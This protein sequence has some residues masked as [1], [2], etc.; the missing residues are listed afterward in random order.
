MR[1]HR[2]TQTRERAG[3][4]LLVRMMSVT[5]ISFSGPF[6]SVS[7]FQADF[8][9]L[10]DFSRQSGRSPAPSLLPLQPCHGN[11]ASSPPAVP[12]GSAPSAPAVAGMID[13]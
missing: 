11:C 10:S 2:D 12:S 1:P 4:L 8:I 3:E 6:I 5:A 7:D 13:S 9:S